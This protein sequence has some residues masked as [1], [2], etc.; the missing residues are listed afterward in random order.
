MLNVTNTGGR[1]AWLLVL[2]QLMAMSLT[3][4]QSHLDGG[5]EGR[6]I[7]KSGSPLPGASVLLV[8]KGG[9]DIE[10]GTMVETDEDGVFHL[11][12]TPTALFV[13]KTGYLPLLYRVDGNGQGPLVVM[14]DAPPEARVPLAV[15]SDRSSGQRFLLV[16]SKTKIITEEK[17]K[18]KKS[19]GYGMDTSMT[20]ISYPEKGQETMTIVTGN[21][22]ILGYPKVDV[23]ALTDAIAARVLEDGSMDISGTTLTGKHWRWA[24]VN[25]AHIEYYDASPEVAEGFDRL[26]SNMCRIERVANSH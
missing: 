7:S 10:A 17:L 23:L 19:Y 18:V 26:I 2:S 13:K 21:G 9:H 6:V 5:F 22:V 4:A 24:F 25:G 16:G 3:F 15:C 12:D 20:V 11:K 1:M 8:R 14:N